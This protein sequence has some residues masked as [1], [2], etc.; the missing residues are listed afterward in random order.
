MAD[1]IAA[2]VVDLIVAERK[3]TACQGE[4]N[5]RN[6]IKCTSLA[7]PRSHFRR[8]IFLI[9]RVNQAERTGEDTVTPEMD[10]H[11]SSLL[12]P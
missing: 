11:A 1:N 3:A 7:R 5:F 12:R 10:F 6:L 4:E 8:L 2:A 9:G